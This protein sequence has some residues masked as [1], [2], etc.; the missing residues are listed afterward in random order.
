MK[1]QYKN[2]KIHTI[3]KIAKNEYPAK[4]IARNKKLSESKLNIIVE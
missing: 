2:K 3:F 1:S 4:E